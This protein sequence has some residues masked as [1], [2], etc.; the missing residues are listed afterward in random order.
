MSEVAINM[1]VTPPSEQDLD[2]IL[3]E[4]DDNNDGTISKDE[5]LNLIMLVLGKMLES[6]EDLQDKINS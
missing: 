3:K 1:G 4:L 2:C 6:E 5:F